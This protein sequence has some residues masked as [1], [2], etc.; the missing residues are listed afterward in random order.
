M[1]IKTLSSQTV[2]ALQ[3]Q[4]AETEGELRDLRFQIAS[5]Q[6]KEVRKVRESRKLV[7]NIRR[8]LREKK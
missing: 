4:L 6:L 3:R 1:D 2:E 5:H 8:I 7:A